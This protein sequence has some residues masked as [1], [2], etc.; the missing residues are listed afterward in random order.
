[1]GIDGVTAGRVSVTRYRVP[2]DAARHR[3]LV[4]EAIA[5]RIEGTRVVLETLVGTPLV[6]GREGELRRGVGARG[7]VDDEQRLDVKRLVHRSGN[8]HHVFVAVGIEY[9]DQVMA[10]TRIPV[11]GGVNVFF[12]HVGSRFDDEL[13]AGDLLGRI[14]SEITA[15]AVKE[16]TAI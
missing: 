14:V 16:V 6:D 15:A 2:A 1:H 12:H 13:A 10:R 4:A 3:N 7:G 11:R 9:A 8:V 5:I